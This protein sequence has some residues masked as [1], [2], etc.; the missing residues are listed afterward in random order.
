MEE[1]RKY[2]TL[3][4]LIAPLAGFKCV[5]RD[6]ESKLALRKKSRENKSVQEDKTKQ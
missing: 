6:E 1:G 3:I 4:R 2:E 5:P